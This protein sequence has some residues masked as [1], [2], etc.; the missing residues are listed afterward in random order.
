[1]IN[2]HTTAATKA[3][4]FVFLTTL[5]FVFSPAQAQVP[6]V[7]SNPIIRPT[8]QTPGVTPGIA[9]GQQGGV[10]NNPMDQLFVEIQTLRQQV[11]E[12]TGLIEQ[13]TYEIKRLKQQRMDDYVDLDRRISELSAGGVAVGGSANSGA[14]NSNVAPPPRNQASALTLPGNTVDEP[15]TNTNLPASRDEASVYPAAFDLISAKQ[16]D[17]AI[18]SLQAYLNDFPGGRYESNAYYWIGELHLVKDEPEKA[19][20][21]FQRVIENYPNS[22]KIF[23]SKYKLGTT[24][25]QLGDNVKA[26]VL[27]EEVASTN[28]DSSRQAALFLRENF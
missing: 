15:G 9:T 24:F 25:F 14:A 7:E 3:A 2:S 20:D 8:G 22:T 12:Q 4:V 28:N 18:S 6:V 26:K 23:A 10:V 1:M 5:L 19:R 17:N 11:Q 27:L 21:A 13:L 16:W